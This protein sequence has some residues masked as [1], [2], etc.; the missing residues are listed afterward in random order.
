MTN[1]KKGNSTVI[2]VVIGVIV[3]GIIGYLIYQNNQNKAESEARAQQAIQAQQEAETA[4]AKAEAEAEAA[5][6]AANEVVDQA[7]SEKDE[8]VSATCEERLMQAKK[9]LPK[10]QAYSDSLEELGKEVDDDKDAA[11]QACRE[12]ND[13]LSKNECD[14]KVDDYI[15]GKTEVYTE[16]QS[17]IKAME[18]TIAAGC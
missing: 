11:I 16:V 12:L 3:V 4:K 13:G 18:T 9:D 14:V 8:I 6:K 15:A 5:K 7:Q 17:K 2:M 1:F 10:L